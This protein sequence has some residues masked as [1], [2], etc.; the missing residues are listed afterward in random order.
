MNRIECPFEQVLRDAGYIEIY[1]GQTAPQK[2]SDQFQ[3]PSKERNHFIR[4]Y[5]QIKGSRFIEKYCKLV[6]DTRNNWC[7]ECNIYKKAP[8]GLKI[9]QQKMITQKT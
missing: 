9:A 1:D 3:V 4:Y 5:Q 6:Y 8:N 7:I 2:Q